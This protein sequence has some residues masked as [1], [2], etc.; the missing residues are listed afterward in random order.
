MRS[1]KNIILV[2]VTVF[3][4]LIQLAVPTLAYADEETDPPPP[5]EVAVEPLP[6]TEE[7]VTSEVPVA[8]EVPVAGGIPA[9][10]S[11]ATEV[12]GAV[13]TPLADSIV[14]DEPELLQVLGQFSAETDVVVLDEMGEVVPLATQQA[15]NI[16]V[17]SDPMWCPVGVT[18]VTGACVYADT[19]TALIPQLT[20]KNED[21][22]IY[23]ADYDASDATFSGSTLTLLADNNLTL[24]G[25]WQVNT[26]PDSDIIFSGNSVFSGPISIFNW[27]GA[28]TVNNITISG[29]SGGLSVITSGDINLGNITVSNGS[30]ANLNNQ[31]GTSTAD[32]TL[33]GTN[34]FN[35]NI[36]DGLV[37]NTNGEFMLTGSLSSLTAN[38]NGTLRSAAG[39]T[40]ATINA[41]SVSI[42]GTGNQFNSN[43]LDGLHVVTPGAITINNITANNNNPTH[44]DVSY[45]GH[46]FGSG[47]F[48]DNTS[49][50]STAS[51]T[52]GGTNIFNGNYNTGLYVRSAGEISANNVTASNSINGHGA[53]LTVSSRTPTLVGGSVTLTG[54]NVFNSNYQDGVRIDTAGSIIIQGI[55]ATGN[56]ITLKSSSYGYGAYLDN[57]SSINNATV[58]VGGTNVFSGNYNNGLYVRSKGEVFANNINANSSITGYGA[59]I[60]NI[61]YPGYPSVTIGGANTFIGNYNTGLDVRTVGGISANN[62]TASGSVTGNGA[63]MSAWG[64]VTLTGTNVFNNN[65]ATGLEVSASDIGEIRVNNLT[66]SNNINGYGAHLDTGIFGGNVTVTGTNVFNNNYGGLRVLSI[67]SITLENI[68]ANEN[69]IYGIN[70]NNNG[71]AGV[72]ISKVTAGNNCSGLYLNAKTNTTVNV[73]NITEN[74]IGIE[75]VNDASSL[76]LNDVNL[77]NNQINITGIGADCTTGKG[78]ATAGNVFVKSTKNTTNTTIITLDTNQQQ[79][80]FALDCFHQIAYLVNLPNGDQVK[81]VCPVSGKARITRLDNTMLPDGLPEGYTYASAFSLEI[82]QGEESISSISEGGHIKMSF[83]VLSS[84]KG[85]DFSALYWDNGGWVPLKDFMLDE[86]GQPRSFN[87]H[88]N[89]PRKIL[90]GLN[91][92]SADNSLRAETST[93]FP[94]IFV[95]AQH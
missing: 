39:G 13:D 64:S 3:A 8:T 11:A 4:I 23:F 5:T 84:Q 93:N 95:L 86:N 79:A 83:R 20:L 17:N 72:T 68:T 89:D 70:L 9:E 21:G 63:Y 56:G 15:A 87:L 58:T 34:I 27:A 67:G 38:E 30:G 77:S 65:Y 1:W 51:I 14:A 75:K 10:A 24:Q 90:S 31:I 12:P 36:Y 74:I 19:V 81:I 78:G 25:G 28:V 45:L 42:G 6:P 59:S 47:A 66:A 55:T 29:A 88:P 18:K 37:V 2:L 60:N 40:G 82:L 46:S 80:E 62:V 54:T 53:S 92:I 94:G 49:S 61:S 16:I 22:V 50:F 71:G 73:G 85:L 48:L 91:F 52:I 33:T 26:T 41:G 43:H 57:T 32:V 35:K 76:V 44:I 69:T 7:S